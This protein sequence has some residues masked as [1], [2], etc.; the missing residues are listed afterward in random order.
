MPKPLSLTSLFT[1]L[2]TEAPASCD[3]FLFLLGSST[4]YTPT[5]TVGREYLRGETLSYTA[6]VIV[7]LLKETPEAITPLPPG[8]ARAFGSLSVDLLNGPSAL[9]SEVGLRI[10][11]SIFLV[12]HAVLR[13]K[14]TLQIVGHSRGAVQALL[15]LHEIQRVTTALR[16]TPATP[17]RTILLDTPCDYTRAAIT[18]FFPVSPDPTETSAQRSQLLDCLSKLVMNSFLIDPVPGETDVTLIGSHFSWRDK[19]IHQAPPGRHHEL[20]LCRDER[21][22]GFYPVLPEGMRPLIM[23]GHHGTPSGNRFTQTLDDLQEG[24]SRF[25]TGTVQNLTLVKLLHFIDHTT[26]LCRPPFPNI[27]LA[28]TELDRITNDYLTTDS[29]VRND[30]LLRHYQSVLESNPAYLEFSK[31]SYAPRLLTYYGRFTAEDGHRLIRQAA[32][33]CSMS[34]L[35]HHNPFVNDEHIQLLISKYIPSLKEWSDQ[36]DRQVAVISQQLIE[37]IDALSSHRSEA[38]PPLK[39]IIENTEGRSI[40]IHSFSLAIEEICQAY[41]QHPLHEEGKARLIAIIS[42]PFEILRRA[43][44]NADLIAYQDFL[45]ECLS[46]LQ[47][48]V[49]QT[50]GAHADSVIQ[51]CRSIQEEVPEMPRESILAKLERIQTLHITAR[52]LQDNIP[53]LQAL[54]GMTSLANKA[55]D[56]TAYSTALI[57]AAGLILKVNQTDLATPPP[58]L[59]GSFFQMIKA[60]AIALGAKSPEICSLEERQAETIQTLSSINT[61]LKTPHEAHCICLIEGKLN[62]LTT[63]YLRHL[64]DK[65]NQL[66][67]V[68]RSDDIDTLIEEVIFEDPKSQDAYNNIREKFSTIFNAHQTLQF[69]QDLPSARFTQFLQVL[70]DKEATLKLHRDPA[71][72]AYFK[73][74]LAVV[75]ILVTGV[76]PGIVGLAVYTL[77][78]KKSPWFFAHS[79]GEQFIE[80]ARSLQIS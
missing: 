35:I 71:W 41:L 18:R 70:T 47:E 40:Y 28:H 65:A 37:M 24:F 60:E 4:L 56:L 59:D 69:S 13:G 20:I 61:A 78:T 57:K 25:D 58:M 66:T 53:R 54:I 5:P 75:S 1:D 16:D 27:H 11:Q 48:G 17:L 68:H 9:G 10:A 38:S 42:H 46:V 52:G 44:E 67:S 30:L 32:G 51:Q 15:L 33:Y 3:H 36:P 63:A 55:A 80:E 72:K 74:C 73:A 34:R 50:I 23:P 26:P 12:L 76:V 49:K 2:P 29:R 31:T 14:L 43:K 19:R 45:T 22:L 79:H 62:P 64:R 77:S 7:S 39:T 8:D 6:Q 21:S